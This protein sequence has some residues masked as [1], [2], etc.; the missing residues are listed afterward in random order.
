[1]QRNWTPNSP[2]NVYFWTPNSE[3][4]AIVLA[5]A[6]TVHVHAVTLSKGFIFC[7]FHKFPVLLMANM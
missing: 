7:E 5:K 6:L 3:I 4:L 2:P 1:M